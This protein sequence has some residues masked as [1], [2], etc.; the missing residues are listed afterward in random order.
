MPTET[1][2]AQLLSHDGGREVFGV[3]HVGDS[4]LEATLVDA[5]ALDRG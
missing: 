2:D 5:G 3:G 1:P 4:M